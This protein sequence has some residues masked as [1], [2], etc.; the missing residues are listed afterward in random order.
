MKVSSLSQVKKGMNVTAWVEVNEE[1]TTEAKRA[2]GKLKGP[3]PPASAASGWP[4]EGGLGEA[5]DLG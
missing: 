4:S 2:Q 5:R 1:T 3:P